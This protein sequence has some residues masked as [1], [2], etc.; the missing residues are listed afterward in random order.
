MPG[1]KELKTDGQNFKGLR[2]KRCPVAISWR[3]PP[4]VARVELCLAVSR[5]VPGSAQATAAAARAAMVQGTEATGHGSR[6]LAETGD[7]GA[8][9]P[10]GR[11]R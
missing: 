6:G 7:P 5:T 4:S 2:V 11:P 9:A 3:G 10:Y 1:D 8:H